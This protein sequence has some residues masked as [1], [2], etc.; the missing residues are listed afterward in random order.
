ME[1]SAVVIK[2]EYRLQGNPDFIQIWFTAFSANVN[3]TQEE[4]KAG[5]VYTNTLVFKIPK[6]SDENDAF[7][8]SLA[9]RRSVWRATDAN[10]VV[11]VIGTDSIPS[12]L[13]FT[14]TI[15][16]QPGNYNGYQLTIKAKSG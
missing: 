5:I 11:H 2:L 3:Q 6:C 9:S 15:D 8:K 7:L 13:N 1:N 14:K 16:G 10:E 12:R 4:T